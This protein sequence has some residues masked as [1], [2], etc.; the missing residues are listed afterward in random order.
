M[1]EKQELARRSQEVA[2][3]EEQALM[4]PTEARESLISKLTTL[5]PKLYL[6]AIVCKTFE[7]VFDSNQLTLE[8]VIQHG[9]NG[10]VRAFA[11]VSAAII[12]YLD[13]INRR[14]LMTD[15]QIAETAQL[16]C[17]EYGW[18]KVDDIALLIRMAKKNKFGKTFNIDGQVIFGW[19]E[20]Y[21]AQRKASLSKRMETEQKPKAL[22]E[23]ELSKEEIQANIER[24]ERTL[25]NAALAM[26]PTKRVKPKEESVKD[27]VSKIRLRVIGEN[28]HLYR[29]DPEHAID[30]IESKIATELQKAG[31]PTDS[32]SPAQQNEKCSAGAENTNQ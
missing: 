25:K 13:Y 12:S 23:P 22:P 2:M 31:L 24:I 28:A 11:I 20:E 8:E 26:K 21:V 32:V 18:L 4:L 1:N 27:K 6:K 16:I 30:I 9:K 3:T 7:D 5:P 14:E 17:E 19:I 29:Q 15:L 10:Q